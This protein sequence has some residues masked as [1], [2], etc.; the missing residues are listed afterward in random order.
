MLNA[1]NNASARES[2]TC[3]FLKVLSSAFFAAS[4]TTHAI[5]CHASDP[6]DLS[7]LSDSQKEQG[8][9]QLQK[10]EPEPPP[11]D[12]ER[13]KQRH[14]YHPN[15]LLGAGAGA[16]GGAMIGQGFRNRPITKADDKDCDPSLDYNSDLP[17]VPMEYSGDP[18]QDCL[19]ETTPARLM[20]FDGGPKIPKIKVD[21][22]A[23]FARDLSRFDAQIVDGINTNQLGWSGA[24]GIQASMG[25]QPPNPS[26]T[27]LQ[28]G[29]ALIGGDDEA[30]TSSAQRLYTQPSI[31][32]SP[33]PFVSFRE[34]SLATVEGN[35]LSPV[36]QW[37]QVAIGMRWMNVNDT[38]ENQ[39]LPNGLFQHIRTRSNSFLVQLS[40]EPKLEF[41]RARLES[42]FQIGA[43]PVFSDSNTQF[44]N[45][46]GA[47]AG[48]PSEIVLDRV[49][50]AVFFK[51]QL[52]LAFPL[53][54]WLSV[55]SG[56]QLIAQSD[57]A[58]AAAQ[59]S[60]TDLA[61]QKFHLRTESLVL[62]SLFVGI[63][64]SR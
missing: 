12:S 44:R 37:G 48:L 6:P 41:K 38:L 15:Y 39:V 27:G 40:I 11:R 33:S 57:I 55:Q 36:S 13:D 28:L 1:Q 23:L 14:H 52:G 46:V 10:P 59:I 35:L 26:D 22:H 61:Q 16:T 3:L 49:T 30:R 64:V 17:Q 19:E 54:R 51:G 32:F 7:Q 58:P 34:M 5:A 4:L 42:L 9:G 60:H 31:G 18:S 50:G 43:G 29:F 20:H 24:S 2:A 25:I 62:G 56:V 45:L 21:V 53:R 63:E 47:P 8:V